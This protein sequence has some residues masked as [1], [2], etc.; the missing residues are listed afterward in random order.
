MILSG[1]LL[2]LDEGPDWMQVAAAVNPLSYVVDAERALLAGD[3]GDPSIPGGALAAA[4]T[5]AVGLILGVRA[6]RRAR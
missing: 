6:M 2:P 1:M 3:F 5:C 4:V